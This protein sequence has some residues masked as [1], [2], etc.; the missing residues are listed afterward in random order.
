LAVLDAIVPALAH[1][2]DLAADEV[3]VAGEMVFIGKGAAGLSVVKEITGVDA[4]AEADRRPTAT[5]P[6]ISVRI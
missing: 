6:S 5:A 3:R 1:V 4:A 2:P